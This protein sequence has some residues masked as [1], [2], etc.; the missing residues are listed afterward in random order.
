[1]L[2]VAEGLDQLQT[3]DQFLFAL[4]RVR[5]RQFGAQRLRQL[6]DVELFQKFANRLGAHF[7]LERVAVVFASGAVFFFVQEL[8][9]LER[10]VARVDDDVVL[11]I[12]DFFQARRLHREQRRQTAR[13]RFEEPNMDDRRG[14]F[15]VP[16]TLATDAAMRNFN[17]AT[18][19]SHPLIFHTAIF[20]AVAF[21]VFFRAENL[22]AE[23][24]VAFRTVG[25][26]IDRFGFFNF[27]LRIFAN[28]FRIR[29]ADFDGVE[30][31]NS[32]VSFAVGVHRNLSVSN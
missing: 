27:A 29:E 28:F 15:N 12:N 21:P 22:F 24:T 16:H 17:A 3:V 11:E 30:V 9:D 5:F 23:Q 19:A 8:T 1:M 10:R 2:A 18:V 25:A 4:L 32:I 13:R 26:V 6:D 14:Q 20:T 31:V 7:R